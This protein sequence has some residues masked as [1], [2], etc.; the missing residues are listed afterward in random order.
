MSDH[1]LDRRT[2][3]KAGALGSMTALTVA[4]AAAA[5]RKS[6]QA[7]PG[8]PGPP[9]ELEEVSIAASVAVQA[10]NRRAGRD[11]DAVKGIASSL[12]EWSNASGLP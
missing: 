4:D 2:F 6:D 5:G 11:D 12:E 7:Q 9:F 1:N 10:I 8:A 3:L